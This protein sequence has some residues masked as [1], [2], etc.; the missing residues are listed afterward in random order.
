MRRESVSFSHGTI[1]IAPPPPGGGG[2]AK[3]RNFPRCTTSSYC[4]CAS[5]IHRRI[6]H[7]ARCRCEQAG[8]IHGT[9]P[10][11]MQDNLQQLND[12]M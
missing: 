6:Q 9:S 5:S 3:A 7:T 8:R 12:V 10:R 2:V 1:K 11:G 4:I